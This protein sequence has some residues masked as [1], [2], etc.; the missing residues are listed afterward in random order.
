MA[1]SYLMITFGLEETVYWLLVIFRVMRNETGI[2]ETICE[3]CF[4][5]S[6]ALVHNAPW[7]NLI[8][9]VASRQLAYCSIFPRKWWELNIV[10]VKMAFSL[11]CFISMLL[12]III[13]LHCDLNDRSLHPW[14]VI[15][16]PGCCSLA[17]PFTGYNLCTISLI[18]AE[19]DRFERKN[20]VVR[21]MG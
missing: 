20:Q 2:S 12:N 10:L 6:H 4:T 8:N 1:P 19:K 16:P 5:K 9:H 14:G 21:K 13:Y 17:N 18:L 3:I 11:P 7:S 15:H